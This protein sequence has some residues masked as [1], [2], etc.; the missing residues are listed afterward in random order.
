MK[1]M[2]VK[3]AILLD[4]SVLIM[5]AF[6]VTAQAQTTAC[7]SDR[8]NPYHQVSNWVQPTR[9]LGATSAV[10]VDAQDNVW[11][12]DRCERSCG[13]S[14]LAPIWEFSPDG[15]VLKNFGAG[16]FDT[17][18]GM[19]IDGDG[20]IW[21]VD[22]GGRDSDGQVIKLSPDG[23]VLMNLNKDGQGG[24][25]VFFEPTAVAVAPNGDIF[26]TEGHRSAVSRMD[27]SNKPVPVAP[28]ASYGDSR[29]L[30]FDENGKFLRTFGRIGSADGELKGP[31]G[32]AIDS[33]G[34]VFVADRTNQRVEIF[35]QNGKFIAAW[36]QFGQPSGLW[37][38]KE[39]T[40]YV[41]DEQSEDSPGLDTIHYP[42]NL[43]CKRGVRIGSAKTGRV[44]YLVPLPPWQGPD[45]G[46]VPRFIG[47]PPREDW[48][49]TAVIEGLAVDSRGAIYGG[50]TQDKT[51]YKFVK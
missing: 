1:N 43:G 44:D 24:T 5:S 19:T 16:L 21:V 31:H 34:R 2:R 8:P 15:K 38:D 7:V 28:N 46:R 17:P 22:L 39:D 50:A 37:I 41:V 18:H 42:A 23:K 36:K 51:I 26:V 48:I 10:V 6:S 20:N 12:A 3:H 35:D 9:P 40:L 27:A 33:R 32:I 14:S 45:E 13:K 11:A 29:V 4:V 49:H 47:Q 30:V 25:D